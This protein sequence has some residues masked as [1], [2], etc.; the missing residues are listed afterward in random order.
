MT[1]LVCDRRGCEDVDD[2]R[3]ESGT[4][5]GRSNVPV[6]DYRNLRALGFYMVT[7]HID[8]TRNYH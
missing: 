1:Q 4:A 5:L 8:G 6:L 2:E 3:S 7:N